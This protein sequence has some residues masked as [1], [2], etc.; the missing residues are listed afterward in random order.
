M[1]NGRD[2][3]LIVAPEKWG[4]SVRSVLM[5]A[6]YGAALCTLGN[7]AIRNAEWITPRMV[8]VSYR[9]KDC[10]GA[11]VADA[12][13]GI[14]MVMLV[15]APDIDGYENYSADHVLC[16]P[17]RARATELLQSVRLMLQMSSRVEKLTQERDAA[18]KSVQNQKIIQRAKA[19]LMNEFKIT[20]NEAHR[21]LQKRSMDTGMTLL[22][23]AQ[24][25]L[26]Q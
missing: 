26:K 23:E 21:I 16:V 4:S 17:G 5:N 10:M 1:S 2:E 18:E 11:D 9:L 20:E 14:C 6:G 19:L 24:I 8:I 25:I 15:I 7:E 13:R 3:I 22:N 12:F